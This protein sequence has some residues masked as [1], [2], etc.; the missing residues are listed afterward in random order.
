MEVRR[1]ARRAKAF[2]LIEGELYK[3]DAAGILMGCILGDQGKELLR[4][5]YA[6]TCR[7]HAG[8]RTLVGKA[9]R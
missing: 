5:I 1:I 8:P 4:E 3:H 7:H 9:F 6:G 2:V